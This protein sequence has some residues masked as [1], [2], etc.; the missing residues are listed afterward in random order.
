MTTTARRPG[1]CGERIVLVL[2]LAAVAL[3]IAVRCVNVPDKLF[4]HDEAHGALR[5]SGF[6]GSELD[7][8]AF[9]GEVLTR[10]QVL[11]YQHP[12]AGTSLAETLVA[13]TDEPQHPPGYYLLTRAGFLF[14]DDARIAM[15][16]V[17]VMAGLLLLPVLY[18]LWTEL[19]GNRSGAAILVSLAALSPLQVLYSQEARQYSLWTLLAFAATAA[20]LRARRIDDGRT[21]FL[22]GV[23]VAAGMYTHLLFVGTV[24][25]HAAWMLLECGRTNRA[26]LAR[27]VAAAGLAGIAFLPWALLVLRGHEFVLATTAWMRTPV[28]MA[29]LLAAWA[30]QCARQFIDVPGLHA[31]AWLAALLVVTAVA[32][33]WRRTAAAGRLVLLSLLGT[34]GVVLGPDLVVS[35]M[36]SMQSRFLLPAL[37]WATVCVAYLL[38]RAGLQRG[39]L[40]RSA[41]IAAWVAVLGVGLWSGLA[42][43]RSDF[44]WSKSVAG[45]NDLN[46]AESLN[47][48][49]RPMLVVQGYDI[50]TGRLLS[51][52]H[53][54]GDKTRFLPIG[55]AQA[56]PLDRLCGD[57]FVLNPTEALLDQMRALGR[58]RELDPNA[59]LWV[60]RPRQQAAAAR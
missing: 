6:S 52:A 51:L 21:W 50:N 58:A 54:V 10:D 25:A 39:G 60:F 53:A 33:M 18:W 4:W 16:S 26:Q 15:R 48:A 12:P 22:Y 49:A 9:K 31:D 59:R 14:S 36:A 24:A 20:L 11:H 27:F 23:I 2:A 5:V 28:P 46:V 1:A 38:D 40:A 13:L 35:G 45:I 57:V 3:G 41:G 43:T 30:R 37:L 42:I 34:W 29:D 44:W 56:L 47:A 19:F 7:R 55:A 8:L 17:S 32:F